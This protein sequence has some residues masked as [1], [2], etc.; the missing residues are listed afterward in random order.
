RAHRSR[1]GPSAVR[2]LDCGVRR[3]GTRGDDGWR[4]RHASLR[5]WR[6]AS[7]AG[8]SAARVSRRRLGP[9]PSTPQITAGTLTICTAYLEKKEVASENINI[10]SSVDSEGRA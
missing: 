6:I 8:A 2:A 9:P 3:P 4:N 10:R 5:R 1:F 7:D